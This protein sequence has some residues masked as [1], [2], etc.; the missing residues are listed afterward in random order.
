LS[1]KI[2]LVL[3]SLISFSS[4]PIRIVE[5]LGLLFALG[6]VIWGIVI[7]ALRISG[8]IE[9]AGYTALMVTILFSSGMIM[10]SLGILGEYIWRTLDVAQNRPVYFVEEETSPPD[11]NHKEAHHKENNNKGNHKE[12]NHKENKEKNNDAYPG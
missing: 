4:V 10:F 7:I 8:S 6:A 5:L 12:A 11:G 2:K 3:D 9:V 1:K